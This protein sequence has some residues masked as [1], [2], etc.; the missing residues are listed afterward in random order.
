M[1][2]T[3]LKIYV[4]WFK[5]YIKRNKEL[6]DLIEKKLNKF[7]K[8]KKRRKPGDSAFSRNATFR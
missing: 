8:N 1:S 4:L 3:S 6:N 5:L 2:Q 7:V